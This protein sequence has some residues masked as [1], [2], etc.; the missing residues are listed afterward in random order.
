ML[1]ST[2]LI[3]SVQFICQCFRP[4]LVY[5]L[6]S[7]TTDINFEERHQNLLKVMCVTLLKVSDSEVHL[8]ITVVVKLG[9]RVVPWMLIENVRR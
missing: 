5:Y 4:S 8:C 6:F 3:F 9:A 7:I 1:Y 2:L